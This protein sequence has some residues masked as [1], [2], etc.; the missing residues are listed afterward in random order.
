MKVYDG[1]GNELSAG[2]RVKVKQDE[3]ISFATV[4]APFP[5]NPTSN[6]PGHWVDIEKDGNGGVRGCPHIC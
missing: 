5:E 6:E 3:G 2:D 1:H 4:I